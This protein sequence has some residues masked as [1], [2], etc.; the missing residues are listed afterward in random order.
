MHFECKNLF[1][2][3][4]SFNNISFENLVSQN[5]RKIK[6]EKVSFKQNAS[7]FQAFL[8]ENLEE[9]DF[10]H[11]DLAENCLAYL[12]KLK[13]IETFSLRKVNLESMEQIKFCG[14]FQ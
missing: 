1:D 3:D 14:V 8:N 12:Y 6:L 2:L 13:N 9:L 4:L 10:S 5:I 11:N 7:S